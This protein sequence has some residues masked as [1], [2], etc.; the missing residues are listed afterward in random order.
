MPGGVDSLL[1][2]EM[3]DYEGRPTTACVL[4]SPLLLRRFKLP[5]F[6][7]SHAPR[8]RAAQSARRLEH[9]R[10][11]PTDPPIYWEHLVIV[12]IVL[13]TIAGGVWGLS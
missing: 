3:L 11:E 8:E 2:S 13:L 12:A 1:P 7:S 10:W 6:Q 4:P 5:H 9:H